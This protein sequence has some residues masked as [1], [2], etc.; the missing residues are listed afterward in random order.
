[1]PRMILEPH[2]NN[3]VECP[4]ESVHIADEL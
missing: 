1:M 4:E 3:D 2:G